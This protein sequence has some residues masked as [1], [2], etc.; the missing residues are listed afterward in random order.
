MRKEYKYS[1]L[2][3]ET[4]TSGIVMLEPSK[5]TSKRKPGIKQESLRSI[6]MDL[7]TTVTGLSKVVMDLSKT[8]SDLADEMHRGFEQ[9]NKRWERQEQF[10]NY[11]LDVFKR[12]NLK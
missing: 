7:S 11:V 9:Q 2:K 5:K 4:N 8:V 12:N 6:V 1:N 3:Q 10:N